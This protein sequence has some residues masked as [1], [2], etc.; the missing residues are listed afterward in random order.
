MNCPDCR[1]RLQ[2]WLDARGRDP[3]ASSEPPPL[4]PA[5]AEWAAAARR[6]DHGLR[7]LTPPAPPPLLA[8]RIVAQ[9]AAERRFRRYR[10]LF[11]AGAVAAA[12]TLLLAVWHAQ[13]AAPRPSHGPDAR[14]VAKAPDAPPV[15]PAP[16]DRVTIQD[17]VT[18]AGSAVASLTTRT[19]G[20]TVEKTKVLLPVVPD[21]SLSKLDLP[22]ALEPPTRSL[23][24]AGEGVSALE[25]VADSARRAVGLFVRD[26]S[27][28]EAAPKTGF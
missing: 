10:V 5:C 7:L 24:E 6:L 28:A 21:P 11:A 13:V 14:P 18:A 27:P 19:A 22:P 4:C 2:Q 16:A 26:L 12:A 1:D 25:P 15:E 3:G 20:E 23:R 17:S 9:V 8:G